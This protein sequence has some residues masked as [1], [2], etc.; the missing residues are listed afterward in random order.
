MKFN[1]GKLRK[2]A[3]FREVVAIPASLKLKKTYKGSSKQTKQPSSHPPIQDA[4]PLVKTIPLIIMV[5]VDPFLPTNPSSTKDATINQS[6]HVPMSRAKNVVSQCD[7][8]DYSA[9]HS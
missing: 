9:T 4:V 1:K 5:D 2:F 3:E 6:P 8:N 7:M